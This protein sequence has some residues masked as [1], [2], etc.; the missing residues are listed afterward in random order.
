MKQKLTLIFVM[1]ISLVSVNAF[2]QSTKLTKEQI[3]EMSI[4]ELSELELDVLM[5][6]VETLGVT[7]VDELFALIM[8]KNVSSASK[9][10]ENSFVSPLS[11]TVLT[12][13]E[14][15]SYGIT[16]IEEAF[17]LIPG[18]IVTEKTNGVYDIQIRGL[19]NIP[20]NNMFLYTENARTLLMIDGRI[21]QNYA[22]GAV[23]FDMMPISIEDIE[24]IEVVRG[25]SSALYGPNAVQGVINIITEKPT[26]SS[27]LISGSFQMGSLNTVIGDVAVRKALNSKVAVGL[28]ANVQRRN[29]PTDK[30]FVIPQAGVYKV[31]DPDAVAAYPA[32]TKETFGALVVGGALSDA[33]KGG[34]YDLNEIEDLRQV[35]KHTDQVTK[36]TYYKL[37]NCVEPETP[38]YSM[39][40]DPRLARET[41]GI[42]GYVTL[43]PS[44]KMRFDLSGGYQSSFVNTTPVGDDYFSFNGRE[45]KTGYVNL[46]ANVFGLSVNANYCGGSNDYAYGVPGFKTW[47]NYFN[48][49]A[50]YDFKLGD[51]SI[52]P[53]IAY[54]NIYYNTYVPNYNNPGTTDYSWTYHN[55]GEYEYDFADPTPHLSSFFIYDASLTNIAPSL[56]L[57]YKLNDLRLIAAI[58]SDKTNAPDKWNTSWQFAANY[59]LNDKNFV[60]LVYSRA[61]SSAQ[62]VNSHSDF[63]WTRTGLM[64]PYKIQFSGNKDAD[65]MYI[66]NFEVGYRWQPTQALLIDAEAFYSLSK[67]YGCLKAEKSTMMMHEKQLWGIINEFQGQLGE[68]G[69][70]DAIASEVRKKMVGI[71]SSKSVISY[72]VMPYEVKQGGIGINIDWIISPKLIAK[73]NAN[74]QFTKI[75]NYYQYSQTQ[76]IMAQ[77]AD[78][79]GQMLTKILGIGLPEGQ[80][81]LTED[82]FDCAMSGGLEKMPVFMEAI[83]GYNAMNTY[84]ASIGWDKMSAAEQAAHLATLRETGI[85]E[86][87]EGTD[88]DGL[89][90]T[91]GLYYGMAF[92]IEYDQATNEYYFGKGTNESPV[93]ENGHKHKATPSVY[94]MFGLIYKPINKVSLSAYANYIG[95]REYTT[96]YGTQKLDDRFTV[97]LKAGYKPVDN[98][99]LFFN[100]HN[101][102]NTKAQE[103]VYSDEIGGVYTVGVQFGF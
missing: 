19:N 13:E 49:S 53:G 57:D 90:K 24:R 16:S 77:M 89:E 40:P 37:F 50:E 10:E 84:K 83:T 99:E 22:M 12:K 55:P 61:N 91:L 5:E 62:M 47:V 34:F 94:G 72:D 6:A 101:L 58:R 80:Y 15:H 102:F 85:R 76:N 88:Y 20:D 79:Q 67:D 48:A 103:F 74:V 93:L 87:L 97:N 75:D 3:L 1:I 70:A 59:S 44:E 86:V 68:G 45:S 71:M 21:S 30:L 39:F 66:D 36:Q 28:T 56:R 27:N 42:N 65:I 96:K 82:L 18:M 14:L 51:L 7:S 17:R 29:R 73:L 38:I 35:Y 64:D 78:V 63:C 60:R 95:E 23:N 100:A 25:G 54:Q 46:N 52:R 26:E 41:M 2:S 31:N 69:S 32:L 4:E 92:G 11:S 9:T 43:T 98:F 8:N 81:T 33:T